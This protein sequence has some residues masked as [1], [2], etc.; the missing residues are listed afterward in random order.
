[1]WLAH[2][3]K[4]KLSV[5][6]KILHGADFHLEVPF[7]KFGVKGKILRQGLKETFKKFIDTAIEKRVNLIIIAGDLFDTNLVSPATIDFLKTQLQKIEEYGILTI[8]LPGTHDLFD[9]QSVYRRKVWQEFNNVYVFNEER[10]FLFPELSLAVHGRANTSNESKTSPLEG[11]LP[12]DSVRFNIAVAHGSMQIKGKSSPDDYPI[13][14]EEIEQSGFDYV[15]LGHWHTFS[16]YQLGTTLVSYCGSAS[17]TNFDNSGC[18]NLVTLNDNGVLLER[19]PTTYHSWIAKECS[20]NDLEQVVNELRDSRAIV[21]INLTDLPN[22]VL[23]DYDRDF[24]HLEIINPTIKDNISTEEDL[25]QFS[26]KTFVGQFLRLA[27]EKMS[28]NDESDESIIAEA[29]EIGKKI[30][31]TGEV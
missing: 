9:S 21:R 29:L 4:E 14:F 6:I 5:E 25:T 28:K 15:A 1:M 17:Q 22:D 16:K 13:T 8:I 3:R 12:D 7:R 10:K 18:V 20:C 27:N 30:L 31:M 2:G 24:F 19:I 23:L 11:L 26:D